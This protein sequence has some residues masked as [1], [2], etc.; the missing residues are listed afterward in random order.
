MVTRR[1]KAL[2]LPLFLAVAV[3]TALAVS[4]ANAQPPKTY[5]TARGKSGYTYLTVPGKGGYTY[6]TVPGSTEYTHLDT[7]GTSVLPSGRLLT[8]AGQTIRISHD[9]FGMAV[10]P[11]GSK[12]VTLHN[13]VFTVIDNATLKNTMVGWIGDIPGNDRTEFARDSYRNS[14]PSPLPN[15]SFLGVAFGPDN[16][17]VYLS[18]GDNGSVIVYDI[19]RFQ[20]LD[21]ISLNGVVDG[22][23]Y[24]DSFTSDLVYN[25]KNNELLVLDRG[26]FRL[27]RIDL[28]TKSSS[29]PSPRAG[30]PLAWR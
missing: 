25:D 2:L 13:G 12:T 6:L 5:P 28:A 1:S 18:G 24:G 22:K 3:S 17:T 19:D 29:P 21:S 8:P 15:G 30:N 4:T 9:P 11:D 7:A 10:S 20:K 23:D 27:V 26:N 16:H 14:I